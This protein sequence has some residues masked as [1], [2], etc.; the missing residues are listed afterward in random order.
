MYGDAVEKLAIGVDNGNSAQLGS[1]TVVVMEIW[2]VIAHKLYL[3]VRRCELSHNV[4]E[5]IDSA[6]GIFIGQ[7]Q[8]QG[9]FNSGWSVYSVARE[10]RSAA[11]LRGRG[12][13]SEG[14]EPWG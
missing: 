3:A 4:P 1:E 6:V 11:I 8:R 5:L 9:V 12:E 2:M 13:G 10:A 7:D 14:I